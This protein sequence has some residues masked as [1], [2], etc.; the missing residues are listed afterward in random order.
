MIIPVIWGSMETQVVDRKIHSGQKTS[1]RGLA[2][3]WKPRLKFLAK[4][5]ETLAKLTS[6]SVWM[7]TCSDETT[8]SSSEETFSADGK[9]GR[10]FLMP[11]S[12]DSLNTRRSVERRVFS[13]LTL[14]WGDHDHR[15]RFAVSPVRLGLFTRTVA[16]SESGLHH[17]PPANQGL[18]GLT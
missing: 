9:A 18:A 12:H 13:E 16:V 6:Y 4:P 3:F 5:F 15:I 11:K 10:E 14:R 17:A 2:W 1:L 8:I 7:S